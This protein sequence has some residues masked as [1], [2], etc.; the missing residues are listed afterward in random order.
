MAYAS[1]SG[2]ARTSSKNPQAFGICDRCG[3]TYNHFK[4]RWQY[5]Y[6]GAGLINKRI[7]VCDPCYDTPQNQLRAIIVP[8]DP[9]P[10]NNPRVQDYA[11]YETD[12]ITAAY[13]TVY[14]PITGIPIPSTTGLETQG[15]QDI[16]SEVIG[17]PNGLEPGANMPLQNN[18]TYNVALNLISVSSNGTNIISVTCSTPHGLVVNSQIVVE[19]LVNNKAN[20][21]YSVTSV[22]S[23]LTFTY[24][25]TNGIPTSGLL[26]GNS[27]IKTANVGLPYN[28]AQIPLTGT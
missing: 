10:I 22:P 13:P 17:T 9:I 6:A 12:D 14:D 25:V 26:Q 21:Y 5:D 7:L 23:T 15:G 1:L 20:G 2:R 3:F 24:T 18:V 28:Y 11:Y 19:G 16:T 27:F 4:L 8:A